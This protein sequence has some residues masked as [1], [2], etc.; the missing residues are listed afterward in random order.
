LELVEDESDRPV[1]QSPLH[2]LP[3]LNESVPC[4]TV[5]I[6]RDNN[7]LGHFAPWRGNGKI[8]EVLVKRFI[9]V[10]GIRGAALLPEG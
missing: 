8:S 7:L 5:D 9:L 10:I 4:F 6:G 2:F 3:H 1:S